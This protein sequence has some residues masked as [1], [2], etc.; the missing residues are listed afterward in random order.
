M[1]TKDSLMWLLPRQCGGAWHQH[2]CLTVK[3]SVSASWCGQ[4]CVEFGCLPMLNMDFFRVLWFNPTKQKHARSVNWSL[5]H[6]YNLWFVMVGCMFAMCVIHQLPN[7]A[8]WS[9]ILNKSDRVHSRLCDLQQYKCPQIDGRT[10]A[11]IYIKHHLGYLSKLIGTLAYTVSCWLVICWT[12]QK[13]S[14]LGHLR[15]GQNWDIALHW[16]YAFQVFCWDHT[17]FHCTTSDLMH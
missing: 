8:V 5:D 10:F 2:V 13:G 17:I 12:V 16:D 4:F 7:H 1:E 15:A 14:F 11:T 3:G 6:R 9:Q